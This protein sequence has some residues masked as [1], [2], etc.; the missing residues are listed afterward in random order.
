MTGDRILPDD[1]DA[2]PRQVALAFRRDPSGRTYLLRQHAAYPFHVGRAL[3]LPGDPGGFCTTYLQSCSGGIFQRDRLGIAVHAEAGA[4]VH[5][6]TSA[7]TVVHSMEDGDAAQSIVLDAGEDAVLE[8]L[9]DPQILF[10]RSRL[11]NR[12]VIRAHPSATVVA[13]DSFLP[14]DP[15]AAGEPFDWL[16]SDTRIEDESG[17]LLAA[18][19]FAVTG[20]DA[21]AARVGIHGAYRMQATLLVVH[22]RD[23]DAMLAVLRGVLPEGDTVYAGASLLPNGAGAWLRALSSDA[24]ALR[25]TLRD[26]WAAVRSA[27]TGHAP[28]PRRK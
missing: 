1:L 3:Y 21:M 17:A 4:G 15:A 6:T 11:A 18:D 14:H 22:R 8:Y 10:P 16:R 2:V 5:V 25:A 9:P 24:V 20:A 12:L 13:C 27:T 23:P 28:G 26:A 7:S 19:R